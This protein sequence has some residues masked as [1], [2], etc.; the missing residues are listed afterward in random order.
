VNTE[1]GDYSAE[2]SDLSVPTLGPDVG[3]YR[4]YDAQAAQQQT[5]TG[6]PGQM[7]YGR[8]DDWASSLS[9]VNPV[10]GDVYSLDGMAAQD[11]NGGR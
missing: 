3:F 9:S 5:Q 7:G 8:T 6:D 1:N 11:G 2:C 4:N 10:V